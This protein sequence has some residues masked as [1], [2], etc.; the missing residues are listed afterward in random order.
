MIF[1]LMKFALLTEKSDTINADIVP[2][3][4][5]LHQA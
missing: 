3:P 2:V 1:I 4:S 5:A